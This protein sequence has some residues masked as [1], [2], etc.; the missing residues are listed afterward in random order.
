MVSA[1]LVSLAK[2]ES[3]AHALIVR[4]PSTYPLPNYRIQ[5]LRLKRIQ[6]KKLL[7]SYLVMVLSRS[8]YLFKGHPSGE[9]VNKG[10]VYDLHATLLRADF[11][12]LF[13]GKAW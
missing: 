2:L 7:K 4:S 10:G 6:V 12:L 8:E 1:L 9:D 11:L 13:K 3:S 5:W